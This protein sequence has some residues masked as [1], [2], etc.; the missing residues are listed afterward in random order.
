M[1]DNNKD[2]AWHLA[3]INVAEARDDLNSPLLADFV[4]E[5][6]S[7]NALAERSAGFVTRVDI[8]ME[9]TRVHALFGSP[10]TVVNLS[11]WDGI[12]S[13][14]AFVYD[15]R[16]REV[17]RR[18]SQWFQRPRQPHLALWWIR[19]GDVPTLEEA[20]ARLQRVQDHGSSP[21]AFMFSN[22]EP[23]PS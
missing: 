17:M 23:A 7:I 20:Q 5:I 4:A 21:A 18:R 11:V 12:E 10:R 9:D 14:K 16:H 13:L 1:V 15:S 19:A 8:P 3:Q 22:P 2:S 6:E